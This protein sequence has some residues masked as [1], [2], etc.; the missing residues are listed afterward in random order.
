MGRRSQRKR[1]APGRAH[2][3]ARGWDHAGVTGD[4]LAADDLSGW[5]RRIAGVL[6]RSG[7]PLL[8]LQVAVLLPAGAAAFGL[9][10]LG[11]VGGTLAGL[12][13]AAALSLAQAASVD[14]AIREA[15]GRPTAVSAA[16]GSGAR[17][18]PAL[19][20]WSALL[21]VL[22]LVGLALAVLPG[23]YAAMVGAAALPGAVVVERAGLRRAAALV[24]RRLPG[25]VLRCAAGLFA[26]AS[27]RRAGR[28]AGRDPAGRAGRGGPRARRHPVLGAGRGVRHGHV[29][30]LRRAADGAGAPDWPQNWTAET[31]T[32]RTTSCTV[33]HGRVQVSDASI[34]SSQGVHTASAGPATKTRAPCG[35]GS[36]RPE[37][38][39]HVAQGTVKWFNAEKG[40][41]FIAVDGGQDVFVHYSAIQMDGYKSLEEGQRVE[42]DVAQGQKGPQ[43]D[44]VRFVGS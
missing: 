33:S 28:R 34:T 12:L 14:L 29:R 8:V 17:R 37:V 7:R 25:T 23:L 15:A 30:G 4:P 32:F 44:A 11:W 16:L 35:A 21:A 43:A 18:T 40:Y 42:F 13:A 38:G 24:N 2:P 26:A 3:A 5:A 31:V 22:T 39:V 19:L 10:R 27:L 6:R 9:T 36:D 41:G 20:G 1:T